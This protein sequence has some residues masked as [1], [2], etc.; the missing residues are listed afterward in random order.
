MKKQEKLVVIEKAY[1][2]MNK[3]CTTSL[4]NMRHMI[5][6]ILLT[7]KVPVKTID[8]S[9]KL[10]MNKIKDNAGIKKRVLLARKK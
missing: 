7:R 3:C 2:N 8:D 5:D 1:D 9:A 6:L 10:F 4:L